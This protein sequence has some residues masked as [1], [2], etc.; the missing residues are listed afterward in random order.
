MF[1]FYRDKVSVL[2]QV[3]SKLQASSVKMLHLV[4]LEGSVSQE[5]V[6]CLQCISDKNK[7][8]M[9]FPN[10]VSCLLDPSIKFLVVVSLRVACY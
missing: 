1:N 3:L 6:D 9:H 8:M 5:L 4:L 10:M 2:S 7:N